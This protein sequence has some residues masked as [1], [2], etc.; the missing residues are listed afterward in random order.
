MA[1]YD[2][3]NLVTVTK[4]NII[5]EIS[6]GYGTLRTPG[7]RIWHQVSLRGCAEVSA[8]LEVSRRPGLRSQQLLNMSIL[9]GKSSTIQNVPPPVQV[10]SGAPENALAA[11]ECT[12]QSCRGAGSNWKYLEGLVRAT[13]ASGRLA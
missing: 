6:C 8:A 12:L 13:G 5:D 1:Y 3:A 7:V 4:T 11:S 10:L 9:F 2:V